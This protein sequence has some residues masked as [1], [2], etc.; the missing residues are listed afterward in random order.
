MVPNEQAKQF[1][2]I[3]APKAHLMYHPKLSHGEFLAL[4]DWKMEIIQE[5]LSMTT[6]DLW[7][8]E[9]EAEAEKVVRKTSLVLSVGEMVNMENAI[10]NRIGSQLETRIARTLSMPW[11][12]LNDL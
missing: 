5:I 4:P 3:L 2:E 11:Q 6:A 7:M 9:N 12:G 8:S 1:L 10:M